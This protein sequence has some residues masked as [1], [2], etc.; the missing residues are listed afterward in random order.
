MSVTEHPLTLQGD[1]RLDYSLADSCPSV[2]D[3]FQKLMFIDE[4]SYFEM[5]TR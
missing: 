2:I 4:N 3:D 1:L 5:E